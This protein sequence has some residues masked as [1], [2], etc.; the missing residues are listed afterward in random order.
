MKD[1]GLDRH[2]LAALGLELRCKSKEGRKGWTE[3]MDI[4]WRISKNVYFA[5]TPLNAEFQRS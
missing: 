4:I 5:E 2:P 3:C 1:V